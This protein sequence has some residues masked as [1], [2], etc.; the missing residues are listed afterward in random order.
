MMGVLQESRVIQLN[1][2]IG[3]PPTAKPSSKEVHIYI[4]VRM[5]SVHVNSSDLHIYMYILI[6]VT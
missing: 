3:L 4:H 5:Y 2:M 1:K 6:T